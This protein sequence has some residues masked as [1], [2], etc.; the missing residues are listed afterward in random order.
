MDSALRVLLA[1]R[2]YRIRYGTGA[3]KTGNVGV[4]AADRRRYS[5]VDGES[6][7]AGRYQITGNTPASE[8]D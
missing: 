3:I 7:V 2:A 6:I 8:I 1:A 5:A 4:V